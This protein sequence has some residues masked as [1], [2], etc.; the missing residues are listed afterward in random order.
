MTQDTRSYRNYTMDDRL[1][2]CD[3]TA[4]CQM[5]LGAGPAAPLH[6]LEQ[7]LATLCKA[8]AHPARVRIVKLLL[9]QRHCICSDIA[10]A[11]P[12]AQSTVSQH[13]KQLKQAGLIQGEIDGP[14]RCYCLAQ[15]R[16]ARLQHLIARLETA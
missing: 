1:P 8:L 2:C 15:D 7:E 5:P 10:G 6:A 11:I 9:A 14:R 12:L 16:L 3:H 4:C 13:L